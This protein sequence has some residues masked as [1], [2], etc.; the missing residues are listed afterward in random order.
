MKL[1][2]RFADQIVGAFLILALGILIF[3]VFM[4][5]SKQRWFAKDY[6]YKTYF[7]S[8]NGLSQNMNIQ[9]KG[10]TIGHVKSIELDKTDTVEVI[11]TIFDTYNDRVR[12]GSLVEL[13]TSPI[14]GGN[15]FLFH[16]GV[17]KEKI[18]EWET[19]H[20]VGSAE[21][22]RLL[23]M[24]LARLPE[25]GDSISNIISSVEDL[26]PAI[27]NT[28]LELQEALK[29]TDESA[30]GRIVLGVE[31]TIAGVQQT[32]ERLPADIEDT[33]SRLMAQIEPILQDVKG[34]SGQIA[35]PEGLIGET[36]GSGDI[37]ASL[38]SAVE[39]ISGILQSLDKTAGF[40]PS[41]L[42]QVGAILSNV[43]VILQQVEDTLT[44][45]NNNPLLKGGVPQ[46]RETP[47]GG[48][49]SR[50]VEF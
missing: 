40:I 23:D 39:S 3:V 6:N 27:T 36:L 41:N 2:I 47:A 9:Y 25:G 50:D 18:D 7:S 14:P 31:G 33:L 42:P 22:H 46:R 10:F 4:L 26:L 37:Y 5:G 24:G 20:T 34:L 49:R 35:D 32:V 30:L 16:P 1:P 28:L 38:V 48:T 43:Y 44:A 21:A 13:Q 19:I 11:F 15:Q 12:E 45:V 17:G 8:A 29:G